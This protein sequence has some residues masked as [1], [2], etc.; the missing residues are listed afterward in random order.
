MP[1][2]VSNPGT[3][4]PSHDPVLRLA[5]G[6][7][8]FAFDLYRQ[9]RTQ[10]GNLVLSPAS[11]SSAL[12]MTWAGARGATASQ[13]KAVL[14][15]E[16]GADEL[17][18]ASGR[19][20][21]MLEDERQPIRF[22]IANRLFGEKT[23]EFENTYLDR[24]RAAFGAPMEL[25][26]FRIGPELA[27][28]HI[29]GWVEK[30]TEARIRDLLPAHAINGDTR[31]VLV[32]AIYFLGD[33]ET[34]FEPARTRSAAFWKSTSEAIE[35]STM[36]R[37]GS[38]SYARRDGISAVE[39]PYQGGALSMLVVVPDAVDGLAALEASLDADSFDA[40]IGALQP[41][42]VWAAIPRFEIAPAE[43]LSL[44]DPLVALGMRDAFDRE[45]ADFTAMADP[46]GPDDRLSIDKVFHKAFVKV[47]EQ[48]TEAAAATAVVMQRAGAAMVKR[49]EFKAD[50]PFLFVIRDR[51]SGL[52]LFM[53]RVADPSRP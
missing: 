6:S 31:L 24:L 51:K 16:G 18:N 28:R 3:A 4:L 25:L 2:A 50:R 20:T 52:V 39:L 45:K 13:M 42:Q 47:D 22:R 53:G 29:N 41:Q 14:H 38:M 48:G 19:L 49:I 10:A 7:N 21:A 17:L 46:P 1:P 12:A 37:V 36:N 15:L 23:F 32:N 44:A 33:W 9:L 8:A 40:L 43:S 11:I 34:P 27:R 30:Q 35:V 5:K 26:D